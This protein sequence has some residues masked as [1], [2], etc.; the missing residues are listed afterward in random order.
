MLLTVLNG[1]IDLKTG[2]L[3]PSRAEDFMTRL[4][5]IEYDLEANCPLWINFLDRIFD[6]DYEVIDYLQ[7]FAGYCL[8]GRTGEQ[9]LLF[10]YGLGCNGKSVLANVLGALLGDYS[11][12]AGAELLM[13]RDNRN[14][15]NNVAALRGARL[16]KVSEFDDGERLAEAQ[17][18][19]LTGGDPVTCRFL[20]QEHFTY[21]PSF[22]VLLIG[23]HKPK[24]RGTDHGIWRRLHL[25]PFRVTIPEEER[26]PHLQ[27]KLMTELPGILVWAVHGCL[28]WQKTGLNPP[29]KIKAATAEYRK[30]EDIFDLWLDD[31][32]VKGEHMTATAA[33][34]L[35][36]FVDFSRWK[37]TTPKK[38]GGM[39]TDAG[40]SREKSN[41]AIRW[42]GLGL[43]PAACNP[44][45][46]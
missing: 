25:L 14:A 44:H 31:C 36:S 7:R 12:T 3:Q 34:L 8:T 46:P 41:G 30:S 39:L 32:C 19:T 10:L 28:E 4:V 33:D 40:F 21:T 6:A 35:A 18:K 26:D 17:I 38:L 37:G 43:I 42:R 15:T 24:I 2:R 45:W 23:N 1:T 27:D 16:V 29:E 9:V 22:K 20:Y 11:S 5:P 13:A